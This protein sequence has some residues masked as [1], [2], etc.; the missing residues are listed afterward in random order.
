MSVSRAA[1]LIH[2]QRPNFHF[3]NKGNRQ[4]QALNPFLKPHRNF[5]E[6]ASKYC[7]T[8]LNIDISYIL[9][10]LDNMLTGV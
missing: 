1:K 5:D 6:I 4:C 2:Y 10:T 9:K 3:S 7:D 8:R